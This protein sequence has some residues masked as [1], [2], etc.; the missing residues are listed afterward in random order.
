MST[1]LVLGS[2]ASGLDSATAAIK[3][4]AEEPTA[5]AKE[6]TR[7]CGRAQVFEAAID[8]ILE[9]SRVPANGDIAPESKKQTA[10]A[11]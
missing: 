2:A 4:R 11:P 6:L 10:S 1:T 5:V 3:Q 9:A 8:S 7:G